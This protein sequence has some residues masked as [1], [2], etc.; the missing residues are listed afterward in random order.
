MSQSEPMTEEQAVILRQQLAAHDHAKQVAA[1]QAENARRAAVIAAL[2]P[3]GAA[4]A[5]ATAPLNALR[6]L[7]PGLAPVSMDL[8]SLASNTLRIFDS[9]VARRDRIVADHQPSPEP[10]PLPVPPNA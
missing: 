10:E 6:D 5:A 7:V 1:V 3:V 2:E 4:L 9:L 8:A